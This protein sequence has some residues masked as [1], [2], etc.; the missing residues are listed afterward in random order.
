M[1]IF[2]TTHRNVDGSTTIE[3]ARNFLVKKVLIAISLLVVFVSTPVLAYISPGK[4]QGYVNDFA[5]IL[6]EG[7]KQT[8][9]AKLHTLEQSTGDEVVVATI[10]TSGK[11]ETIETYAVK[12]F[13]EWG[14]GNKKHDNGILILVS[15]NDR[16]NRIEVGYGLEGTVTDIQSGN[17]I[18]KVMLPEFKN[19]DYSTGISKAVDAISSIIT[20]SPD[21]AQYAGDTLPQASNSR[22]HGNFAGIFFLIFI[23]LNWLA[24]ILG[25][26]KS[27]WLGGVIGAIIGIIVG[28]IFGFVFIGVISIIVLTILGLIFDYIVSKRPP[29]SDGNGGIWPMF[30]GG[31]GGFGGSGGFGG[32]GGGS[33]GGGGASGRW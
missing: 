14:I 24:R 20:N 22:T 18:Q 2:E 4:P 32:F 29:G 21:A 9:E 8:I 17:I 5:H 23:V 28:F 1:R 3:S 27:W 13:Q 16:Q 25:A 12:L 10:P 15:V 30:F 7:D 26:T 31:G 19:S 6:S 11:D 33:S